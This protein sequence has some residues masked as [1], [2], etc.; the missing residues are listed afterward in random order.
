MIRHMTMATVVVAALLPFAASAQ[1]PRADL[2]GRVAL[3]KCEQGDSATAIPIL[4][5]KLTNAR[6]LRL[7]GVFL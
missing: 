7:S 1:S 2:E 6:R 5:R 3:A 4:E